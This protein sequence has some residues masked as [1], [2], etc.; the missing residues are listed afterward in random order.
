MFGPIPVRLLSALVAGAF[1]SLVSPLGAQRVKRDTAKVAVKD[2]AKMDHAMPGMD[3]D[4]AGMD[5]GSSSG[6]KMQMPPMAKG[7]EMPMIP[8]MERAKPSVLLYRPGDGVDA[9]T[10]AAAVP[11]KVVPLGDRDT[12]DL[13]AQLVRRTILGKTHVMFGF[14]GQYPGPLIRVKQGATITVK[15]HNRLD[16]P[17]A[18]HWHG[19]RLDNASDGAV[20]V[21]QQAVPPGGDFTYT[22]HFVDA[23]I[24]WYHP[25]VREDVQQALGLFG[26]MM[27]DSPDPAYYSAVN[28]E[29]FLM[30]DDLLVDDAGI[31]PFGKEAANFAIM[32]R[33]GNVYLLNGE[34]RYNLAV[35]RGDVVRFF[36]TD[37]SNTRMYNLG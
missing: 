28:A 35:H 10:L 29:E 30:L 7:L 2:T 25:H 16:Q 20:G 24:Y 34:P 37:V 21:T 22:V 32:G 15:F 11:R 23:G 18:V 14:N 19:V 8:G 3:H 36:L 12:L 13:T 26:N 4:M 17:S 5:H 33:F 9:S 31:F 1:I 6:G 27:V